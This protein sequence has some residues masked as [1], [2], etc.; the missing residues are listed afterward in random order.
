MATR[1]ELP[2]A[3]LRSVRPSRP[4]FEGSTGDAILFGLCIL[5]GVIAAATLLEIA[6]QIFSGA[7]PAFDKFG[8]GFVGDQAWAP[9]LEQF[10]AGTMLYGTAV[11]SAIALV[12]ATPLAVA[13]ALYLALMAP[14]PVRAVVGPLV[15]MLA[16]IP[17]VIVGFFGLVVL[18]PVLQRHVDPALHSVLGFL[19][20]F[21]SPQTTG[22]SLFTAGLVLTVM[23]VPIIASLSRDLFL[24]VPRELR[25][26]AEA[27]GCTQWEVIRGVILP[28]TFSGVVAATML[29]LGRALG[30]AI[31]AAEVLG[32]GSFINKNLFV[33]GNTLAAQ[34]A[35]DIQSVASKL[36]NAAIFYLAAILLV[37]SV[38]TNLL[39]RRIS[40]RYG[41]QRFG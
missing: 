29:G 25:E 6:Y 37:M 22:L 34:I 24:T 4:T 2:G 35:V 19:P 13:I 40:A 31:A 7:A 10:G 17:S 39:A 30:E 23:V 18:A 15:E 21:G 32:D 12:I 33:T 5:A 38:A 9:N 16:A 41:A 1:S 27:L 28:T 20:I 3:R 11:T 26:G 14:P 36:E 8:F